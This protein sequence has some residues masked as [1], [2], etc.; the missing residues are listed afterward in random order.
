MS[1]LFI[2]NF[3]FITLQA[4]HPHQSRIHLMMLQKVTAVT[5]RHQPPHPHSRVNRH[6]QQMH[7]RYLQETPQMEEATQPQLEQATQPRL[8]QATQPRLEQATRPRL[9]QTTQPQ[10]EQAT[11]PLALLRIKN[12][13]LQSAT[14]H[15][16]LQLHRSK[17]LQ[18]RLGSLCLL[19]CSCFMVVTTLT[20]VNRDPS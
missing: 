7:Q 17:I 9:D 6:Q 2:F 12:K 13:T 16:L 8:E 15:P 14:Q 19:G 4:L 20:C 10:L 1:E 3:H 5:S 11:Q 18:H